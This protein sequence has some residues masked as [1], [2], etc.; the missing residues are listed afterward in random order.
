MIAKNHRA[1][2]IFT[3]AEFLYQEAMDELD[4]GKMRNAAEKSWGATVRAVDAL[5]LARTGEEPVRADITTRRLRKLAEKDEEIEQRIIGRYYT[6]MG[7]LHG[8]CFYMGILEPM[9][10]I[11]RRIRQTNEFIKDARRLTG[12]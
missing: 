9:D 12:A 3:D 7:I 10:D 6:R 5:V 1:E 11:V 8:D 2:Q 4:R